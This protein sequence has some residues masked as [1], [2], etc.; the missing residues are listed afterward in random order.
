MKMITKIAFLGALILVTAPL[1]GKAQVAVKVKPAKPK[2][3]VVKPAKHKPG[4]YWSV[5][6]WKWH[7][8]QNKYTWIKARWVKENKGHNWVAG[9]W[10]KGPNGHTWVKGRWKKRKAVKRAKAHK[11]HHR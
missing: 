5:G 10:T 9:H 11:K 6:H 7:K 4:H 3:L 2:V 8:K 1:S